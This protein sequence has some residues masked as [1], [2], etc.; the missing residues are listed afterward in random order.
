ML[1]YALSEGEQLIRSDREKPV[2][3]TRDVCE[4]HQ[5]S[6]MEVQAFQGTGI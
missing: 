4:D 3:N 5:R 6:P 1:G 2:P